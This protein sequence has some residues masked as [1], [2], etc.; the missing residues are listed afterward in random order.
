MS[1]MCFWLEKPMG[2]SCWC[3]ISPVNRSPHGCAKHLAPAEP[4]PDYI[5]APPKLQQ[6]TYHTHGTVS[7]PTI[8]HALGY[9]FM[10]KCLPNT[11]TSALHPQTKALQHPTSRRISPVSKHKKLP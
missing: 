3:H 7:C 10:A 6:H 11:T 1:E 8:T 5:T 9:K 4:D 2:S